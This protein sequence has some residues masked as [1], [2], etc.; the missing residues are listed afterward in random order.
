M[1]VCFNAAGKVL[2]DVEIPAD[3]DLCT[4]YQQKYYPD[5][6]TKFSKC[7]DAF[8]GLPT[9]P[10]NQPPIGPGAIEVASEDNKTGASGLIAPPG[11]PA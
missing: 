3:A 8:P 2:K 5:D 6:T 9:A 10:G 1:G 11:L 7:P 4:A